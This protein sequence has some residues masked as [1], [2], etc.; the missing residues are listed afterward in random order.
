[1]RRTASRYREKNF[2]FKKFLLNLFKSF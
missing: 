1:M 2:K